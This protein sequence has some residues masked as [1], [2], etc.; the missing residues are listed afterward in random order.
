MRLE[1]MSGQTEADL[2]EKFAALLK[3]RSASEKNTIVFPEAEVKHPKKIYE[4][5]RRI[6]KDHIENDTDL[7]ILTYAD[8]VFYAVRLEISKHGFEG[9]KC[10]QI[11]DSGDDVCVDI[12]G[13]GD[14][15]GWMTDIFDIDEEALYM[16]RKSYRQ[17]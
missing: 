11:L 15:V 3:S 16:L 1:I 17:I 12:L 10:H 7:F 2:K 8:Y 13:N 4:E 9:A 14:M 6:V 5:V